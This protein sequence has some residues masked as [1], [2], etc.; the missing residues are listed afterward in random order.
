MAKHAIPRRARW[1]GPE[2]RPESRCCRTPATGCAHCPPSAVGRARCC[3]P[4]L[5]CAT[6]S[7]T[8]RGQ[9]TF[10]EG[11][12]G[13]RLLFHALVDAVS[14][15]WTPSDR[16]LP[17]CK[18]RRGCAAKRWSPAA[19]GCGST[20]TPE[21]GCATACF[22]PVPGRRDPCWAPRLGARERGFCW[23]H[24]FFLM[25][26]DRVG[27]LAGSTWVDGKCPCRKSRGMAS[28]PEWVSSA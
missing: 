25:C 13:V 18:E 1:N 6:Q 8:Q 5:A 19:L 4:A 11:R 21:G 22:A 20:G 24:G 10:S 14:P 3:T 27:S 7:A 17:P 2:R 16:R 12:K 23:K 15:A 9:A 28:C 26:V